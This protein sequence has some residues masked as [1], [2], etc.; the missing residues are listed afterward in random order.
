MTRRCLVKAAV[1]AG[2]FV[3]GFALPASAHAV[4][5]ESNPAD[6]DQLDAPPSEVRLI[7]N[8]PVSVTTGSVRVYDSE[9]VRVDL[10]DSRIGQ[11]PEEVVASLGE[12]D[13]GHFVVTWRAV[14]ADG[15]PVK[16]A[17]LFEVGH[18]GQSVDES[19]VVRLLGASS[20]TPFAVAG[21]IVRWLTYSAT[22]VAIGLVVFGLVI[23]TDE[24]R[25]LDRLVKAAVIVGI[26][27]S[28]F[29]VPLFAAEASGLGFS[30]LVSSEAL[31]QAIASSVALSALVR[32]VGLGF[33]ATGWSRR[34]RALAIAG[35]SLVVAA[36]LLTGHTRTTDPAWVVLGA[37]AV[38][39]LCAGIWFGGLVGLGN[40]IWSYRRRGDAKNAAAALAGF[41]WLAV[42]TVVA[43]TASGVALAYL[44][45][46][47]WHAL[48][49]TA[50]GWT[51]MAKVAVVAGVVGIATY[52]NRVLVPSIVSSDG[53]DGATT[54][55][56]KPPANGRAWVRLRRAMWFEVGGLLMV[57][58][59]T[60]LLVNLQ[61]A[62]EAAGVSGPY[63]TYVQFG[64]G[65]LN[66]VVDP[67]RVGTNEIHLYVLT[68]GGLPALISGDMT[69]EMSMPDQDI[70]PIVRSP[71][72]AGP[73]H[74][75][76]VGPELAIP[77]RW[78]ITV[79]ERTSQFEERTADVPVVVNG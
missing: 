14:S 44:E 45:V 69:L 6:G 11:D 57:I 4:L 1:L 52:N 58:G 21:W 19:F 31:G 30:A 79:R 41:S 33:V 63:S 53:G 40:T 29:E 35:V 62:A 7:F 68:P 66:L 64:D 38:H 3:I 51:L 47:A 22:L 56:D 8:E 17:F 67:N 24:T 76:Q 18:S 16:G 13:Q 75:I 23:A 28:V 65:Q 5:L 43:L 2:V 46:R 48:T 39:V 27:G 60:A 34:V 50:Y 54:V 12:L 9:G 37:D 73:G 36:E 72:V 55:S 59:I 26:V 10:G 61:P 25:H 15:H 32:S 70:G 77:G 42:Y 78:V 20:D 71:R 74:Y 49:S